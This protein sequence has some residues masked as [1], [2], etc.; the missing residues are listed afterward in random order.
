[1]S[2]WFLDSE[3]STCCCQDTLQREWV[4]WVE[5][6]E[7]A[8]TSG[9]FWSSHDTNRCPY[10]NSCHINWPQRSPV[11]SGSSFSPHQLINSLHWC[12]CSSHVFGGLVKCPLKD[13]PF[14]LIFHTL[15]IDTQILSV[16]VNYDNKIEFSFGANYVGFAQIIARQS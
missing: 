10:N 8:K 15:G 7:V 1:M 5:G 16:S 9:H 13:R 6:W 14:H 4:E 12:H 2:A 3:L 11:S